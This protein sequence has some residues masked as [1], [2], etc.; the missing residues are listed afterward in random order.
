MSSSR[1]KDA[2]F[3]VFKISEDIEN[4]DFDPF[5]ITQL[6]AVLGTRAVSQGPYLPA[7][8]R[9]ICQVARALN[10]HNKRVQA[11]LQPV[12]RDDCGDVFSAWKS[13]EA[14]NRAM[15]R[16]LAPGTRNRARFFSLDF[17]GFDASV[18]FEVI[19]ASYRVIEGCFTRESRALIRFNRE[20]FKRMGILCPGFYLPGCDRTGGVPSGSVDTNMIDSISNLLVLHYAGLALK[21]PV[22]RIMVQGD[23]AC[24][25]MRGNPSLSDLAGMLF[26][27]FGMSLSM[28]KTTYDIGQ[29]SFLQNLHLSSYLKRGLCVGMRP[30]MHLINAMWSYE[31]IDGD[32]W[33]RLYDSIRWAQQV[34]E[35]DDHPSAN[36]LYDWLAG[37]DPVMAEVVHCVR[38]DDGVRLQRAVAAVAK[39][40]SSLSWGISLHSFKRSPFVSYLLG[41]RSQ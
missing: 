16:W 4:S 13:R 20:A 21:A 18:P 41:E 19:D 12:L 14:V 22:V 7:K 26:E 30:I 40:R 15:T 11:V 6:P 38:N 24:L 10:N 37:S 28:D 35:G 9:A 39:K 27:S 3:R 1:D 2:V 5:W 31:R 36:A 8:Y 33:E 17:K 34:S 32:D 29:I 25:E 23:D